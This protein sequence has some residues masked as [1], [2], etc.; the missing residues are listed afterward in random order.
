[1]E[2]I[3]KIL[4]EA[5]EY[6]VSEIDKYGF[7]T[8]I[9]FEIT[10]KEGLKLSKKIKADKNI[11]LLGV[12]LMDIKLGQAIKENKLSEHVKTGIEATREFLNKFELD[13][14]LKQKVINCVEA[15]HKE[16]PFA[17]IEAEICANADCYRFIHPKG[18]FANL[19]NLGKRELDYSECLKKAEKKLDEKY[20]ILS[21]EICKK[22]LTRY[23]KIFKRFIE[24]ARKEM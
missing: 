18:F 2:E 3:N 8:L 1:M 19:T 7:P 24:K 5:R 15:H 4:K 14:Q 22:E 13:E 12:Y 9:N 17:C 16:I 11:V 20:S 10:E 23:Y 21:L 6:A